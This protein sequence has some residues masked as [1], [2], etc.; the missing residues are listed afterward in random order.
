M[1]VEEEAKIRNSRTQGLH[2]SVE[3]HTSTK[4]TLKGYIFIIYK[5]VIKILYCNEYNMRI[6]RRLNPR[7]TYT[8][9]G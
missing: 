4:E 5:S 6:Y 1:N 7:L 9:Y 8:N 2:G 3:R